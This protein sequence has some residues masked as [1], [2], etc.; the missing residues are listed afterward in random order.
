MRKSVQ[1]L[2]AAALFLSITTAAP[3]FGYE[4]EIDALSVTMAE[5]I[6]SKGKAKVAVVD[7]AD[8]EG[9]IRYFDKFIAEQFS[10]ALAGAGKGF[11]V[12]DRSNLNSLIKE[13][14][15]SKTGM[16]DPATARQLGK[17]AGVDALVTGTLTPIG[18]NVQLIVKVLD[19]ETADVIDSAKINIART[20]AVNELLGK[21]IDT[22]SLDSG[23]A[24]KSEAKPVQGKEAKKDKG[25]N[26]GE[27]SDD[28]NAGPK[29]DWKQINGNWTM[30]NGQ[31]TVTDIK[32]NESYITS[33]EG[34]SWKNLSVDIDVTPG[35][36]SHGDHRLNIC[37]RMISPNERICF[38]MY[39]QY[40]KF[41]QAYWLILKEGIGEPVS[42][43][44]METAE[45]QSVHIKIEVKN[46]VFT[47]YVNGAQINQVYDATYPSGSV[48]LLQWYKV[49]Y[50]EKIRMTFDNLEIKPLAD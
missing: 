21:E 38:G 39:S 33:L 36:N 7:F 13:H 4:K 22:A 46:G 19:A 50:G 10:V 23:A 25:G 29:P 17:V 27:F 1:H 32:D 2:A 12:I 47:A 41:K 20:Q 49:W 5:K 34:K 16:I 31:Y 11:R 9:N 43:V 30:S 44:D 3:A 6:A 26:S 15:L 45:G 37:P 35:Y 40:N 28:F 42:R 14:K 18:D 48:G 24:Q 8:L